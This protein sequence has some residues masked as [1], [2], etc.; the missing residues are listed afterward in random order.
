M[1]NAF[2]IRFPDRNPPARNTILKNVRKYQNTGTS[3][4]RNKSNSGKRR[5][6]QN[7]ANIAAVK[8]LLEENWRWLS[9]RRNAVAVTKSSYRM[10]VRHELLPNDLPSRLRYSNWFKGKWQEKFLLSHAKETLK[11]I[12]KS[13]LQNFHICFTLGD[14]VT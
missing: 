2:K 8:E 10:H 7:K 11:V 6:A 9:A 5:T 13:L 4:N 1:E 14:I 3:L 12:Y